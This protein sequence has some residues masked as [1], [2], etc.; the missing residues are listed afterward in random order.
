M[1]DIKWIKIVTDM[2]NHRKIKQIEAMPDSDA[3]LV[4]WV[5]LLCLAGSVNENGAIVITNEVPYTD[6]MLSQEF[7]RPLNTIRMALSIFQKY[8]MIEIIDNVYCISN[9]EKYQNIEGMD[10]IREQTRLR[11][12]ALR[13]KRKLLPSVTLQV[14]QCNATELDKELE[15]DID[16]D[17]NQCSLFDIFWKA[18][19]KKQNKEYARKCFAKTKGVKDNFDWIMKSLSLFQTSKEWIKNDGEFIPHASTW[20]NGKRWKDYPLEELEWIEKPEQKIEPDRPPMTEEEIR[21]AD[22]A[23]RGIINGRYIG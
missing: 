17:I 6:E 2:F 8:G 5:K 16:K 10:K 3:V 9:W 19:P 20:L 22:D 14:T 13:S 18:Y 12:S 4:I 15:Q 11:V 7:G 21:I 23:L 1:A